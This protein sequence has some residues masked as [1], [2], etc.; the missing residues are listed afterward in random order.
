M[1]DRSASKTAQS[2]ACLECQKRKTRCVQNGR[3]ASCTYC[4]RAGKRCVFEAPPSRVALT[5]K[6]FDALERRCNQLEQLLGKLGRGI[7][8][9]AELEK[10]GN[11]E[12]EAGDGGL[13][14]DSTSTSNT[15]EPSPNR[16]FEWNETMPRTGAKDTDKGDGM[17][18]GIAAHSTG[19]LG[20][21]SASNIL[22][23]I[24]EMLPGFETSQ[25]QDQPSRQTNGGE[26]QRP[27]VPEERKPIMRHSKAVSLD[28]AL[29]SEAVTSRLVDAYFSLYNSSYPILHERTFRRQREHRKQKL[30][31][32]GIATTSCWMAIYNLVLAIGSWTVD[33]TP[34]DSNYFA[35][36]RSWL[37]A[38]ALESGTLGAV[39]AFL[40]MV[41]IL[42]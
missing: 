41:S 6:N 9:D 39:Q 20:S 14:V 8:L 40:L 12:E 11:V 32:G 35:A 33:D 2:R 1:H 5:R 25:D 4:A 27:D 23:S 7:N 37:S 13:L 16:E 34:Q 24:S 28:A 31:T 42:N 19:Y 3:D 18:A 22:K 17:A 29:V 26:V 10:L 15:R 36:T 38:R 30:T 21:S